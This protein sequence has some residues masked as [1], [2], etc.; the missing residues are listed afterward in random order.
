MKVLVVEDSRSISH[1]IQAFIMDLGHEVIVADTGEKA[2]EVFEPEGFDLVLMD[3]ELP[4]INGFEVTRRIRENLGKKW[5]PII[6][7]SAQNS[8]EHFVEGIK[9][10]GDAYLY[11]P[12]N[13]PVLQ[14]MVSAMGRIASVQ[15]ALHQANAKLEEMAYL[16]PLTGL[17]NRRGMLKHL[18]REWGRALRNNTTVSLL[19]MD[20]DH[21]KAYN[22]HYGHL[23]G[24]RCLEQIGKVLTQC[25]KRAADIGCRYGGEEF[26][27][28]L[29][30]TDRQGA[31]EVAKR[32]QAALK[33]EAIP[34]EKSPTD[35]LVTMS[36]GVVE[37]QQ[38]VTPEDLIRRADQYLY[39]AK[40]RGR[41]TWHAGD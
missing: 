39:E 32:M 28:L 31:I 27:V 12:V 40:A 3:I 33:A 13:G 10:G 23:E 19:V 8:D 14:S 22:D 15:E 36:I 38:E 9:A 6:F 5:I 29:P 4:G 35:G 37:K 34:H 20:V 25:L 30:E 11:K 41:N 26:L 1:L 7:L 24:D 18:S 2:L 17:Y 21:F 16:D